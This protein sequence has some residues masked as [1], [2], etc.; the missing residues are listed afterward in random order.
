MLLK[1]TTATE[2]NNYGFDVNENE[3]CRN[4]WKKIGF[5]EG[6]G[7]SNSYHSYKFKDNNLPPGNYSYR[8][9]QIDNDGTFE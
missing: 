7:T 3:F 1:W 6:N 8:L 2:L 4:N 5:V 9:K